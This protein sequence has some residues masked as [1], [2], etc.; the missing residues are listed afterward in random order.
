MVKSI[1]DSV[2]V[3]L[4]KLQ[5][6]VE[7]KRSLACCSPWSHRVRDS[8]ATQQQQQLVSDVVHIHTRAF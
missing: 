3:N 8:L 6:M 4:S 1:T 7:G 2:D 5:E